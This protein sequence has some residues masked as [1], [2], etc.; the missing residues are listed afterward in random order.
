MLE[1]SLPG[2]VTGELSGER[3]QIEEAEQDAGGGG[4]V[5]YGEGGASCEQADETE[6]EDRT[7]RGSQ[8][9]AGTERERDAVGDGEPVVGEKGPGD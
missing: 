7:E 1:V 2:G 6:I 4:S 5:A 9:R 3:E 8:R